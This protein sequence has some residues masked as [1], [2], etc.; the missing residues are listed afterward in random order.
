MGPCGRASSR[1]SRWWQSCGWATAACR[2]WSSAR[3]HGISEQTYYR[4][5]KR[6]GGVGTAEVRELRQLREENRKLKQVVAD[7]ML[8]KQILKEAL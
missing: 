6:F 7:L 8:D 4:W 3:Q 5:R 2:S 1:P